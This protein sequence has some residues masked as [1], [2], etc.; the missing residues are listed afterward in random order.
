MT[1]TWRALLDGDDAGRA[2][3]AIRDVAEALDGL[4]YDD[5]GLPDGSA[6]LAV[7]FAYLGA[8]TG[9][10]RWGESAHRFLDRAIDA[11]ADRP[12]SPPLYGGFTGIAWTIEH[13]DGLL[14]EADEDD[15]EDPIGESLV[16]LLERPVKRGEFDLITGL[17]GYGVYALEALPRPAARRCVALVIERLAEIGEPVGDGFAWFTPPELL[18][19]HQRESAPAGHFN[20]GVA[21]GV[22]AV[23]SFLGACAGAG[24][25]PESRRPMLDGAVAWMLAQKRQSATGW[26]FPSWVADGVEPFAARLAWCY[27]DPGVAAALLAA[28]RHVGRG[29]WEAEA[30]D[31]ARRAAARDF[32]HAG[33]LDAGLCHGSGGLGHLFNRMHQASGDPSLGDAARA[34]YRHALD[35]HKPGEGMGGYLTWAPED[36]NVPR[37]MPV[38]GFLL[39]SA[40]V[41]LAL[42]GA[43]SPLEPAWD[44]SLAISI[45]LAMP[46]PLS[47]GATA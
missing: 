37:W 16:E 47:P 40:G 22:P 19:P 43:V 14:F 21:H 2:W 3:A 36:P 30:L 41:A 31:T 4:T 12:L 13:L 1:T 32:Q 46:I 44:R 35:E 15:S 9:E 33:V 6:G 38:P 11:L 28:A 17:T 26:C 29:D 10:E 45:P 42:L 27:G 18:P 5:P 34:W 23:V 24:L 8:A 25:L 7:F 20:L 39:G